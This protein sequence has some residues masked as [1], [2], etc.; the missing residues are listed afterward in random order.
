MSDTSINR[1]CERCER[2]ATRMLLDDAGTKEQ[3]ICDECYV[4]LLREATETER[5]AL[6]TH[7]SDCW[8][9]HHECAKARIERVLAHLRMRGESPGNDPLVT[10][11]K[12][13]AI[14]AGEE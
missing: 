12:L 13:R 9:V 3:A 8:R 2:D 5:Q 4:D 6:C 1:K 7:S 11:S 10:A 14:I